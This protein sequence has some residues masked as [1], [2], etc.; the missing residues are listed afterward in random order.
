MIAPDDFAP[1]ILLYD[2]QGAADFLGPADREHVTVKLDRLPDVPAV[3]FHVPSAPDIRCIPKREGQIWVAWSMESDVWYPQ[4]SSVEDMK[5]FDL[6]MTYRL[7][8]DIPSPYF[9]AG[10][11]PALLRKPTPKTESAPAVFLASGPWDRSGRLDY[12]R[13]LMR[14]LQVHSYGKCLNNRA[15]LED[16]GRQTKLDTVAR[17]K[18]TLAFENSLTRDY[19]TEKFFDPLIAGSVPVYLGAP[20][21]EEFAPGK[22]CFINVSSFRDARALADYL[23]H[24]AANESEYESHLAWKRGP[25]TPAFLET[26]ARF[27]E[28]PFARLNAMLRRRAAG[29]DITNLQ[30][31]PLHKVLRLVT[32][33]AIHSEPRRR[34]PVATP[35]SPESTR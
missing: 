1:I 26:A 17:Y 15:L 3:V 12:V 19:V 10:M 5:Y 25:L 31:D 20:N 14:Y 4:L 18:F 2:L 13:E 16:T 35:E 33:I 7:D 8:S 23:T 9:G 28:G 6:T 22:H 24:L 27:E 34:V 21:I 32:G 29:S 11:N 30:R